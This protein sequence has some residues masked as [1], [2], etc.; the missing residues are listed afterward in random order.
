VVLGKFN[1]ES[2]LCGVSNSFGNAGVNRWLDRIDLIEETP[3]LSFLASDYDD[4]HL[5]EKFSISNLLETGLCQ[6]RWRKFIN[7]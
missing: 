4:T 6:I 1:P 2:L 7:I 3:R 5:Q